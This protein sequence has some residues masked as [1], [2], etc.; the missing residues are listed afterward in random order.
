M[1]GQ[2]QGGATLYPARNRRTREEALRLWTEAN[3]WFSAETGKK[4]RIE[5]G[6]LADLAVL[7]DDYFAVPDHEI[8]D[9]TSVLALLGGKPVHTIP[10]TVAYRATLP[11]RRWFGRWRPRSATQ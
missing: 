2:R 11:V 4:G 5:V 7:S 1:A 10:A 6:P 3:A 9:I 8:T